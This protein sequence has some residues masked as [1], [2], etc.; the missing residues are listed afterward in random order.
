M[1]K[2]ISTLIQSTRTLTNHSEFCELNC[3]ANALWLVTHIIILH[4]IYSYSI[5]FV[6]NSAN[7][8]L[9]LNEP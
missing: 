1:C 7:E 2:L 8:S 6:H 5:L 9:R 3:L 4:N